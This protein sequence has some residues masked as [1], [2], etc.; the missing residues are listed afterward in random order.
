VADYRKPKILRGFRDYLPKAQAARQ[1]VVDTIRG[2][3]ESFGF[4]PLDTPMLE[5]EE[6]LTGDLGVDANKQIYRF[7]DLDRKNV[8]LP[9]DLTVSLARVVAMYPNGIVLP[10]KRYQFSKVFRFDKIKRGRFREFMQLDADIVGVT[11]MV[12]DAEIVAI[13]CAALRAIGLKDFVVRLNDRKVISEAIVKLGIDGDEKAIFRALDKLEKQNEGEVLAELTGAIQRQAFDSAFEKTYQLKI[14][15]DKAKALLAFIRI[16]EPAATMV[17]RLAKRLGVE[18]IEKSVGLSELDKLLKVIKA[19]GVDEANYRVDLSLARGLDYYTG[20]VFETV[21]TDMPEYGSISG[22]GRYDNLV[23]RFAPTGAPGVGATIGID[24]LFA[25]LEEKGALDIRPSK[26]LV[27]IPQLDE[28]F[29]P[30]YQSLAAR[31][32]ERGIGAEVYVEPGV[33]LGKQFQYADRLGIPLAAIAGEDEFLKGV[34]QI[35]RLYTGFGEE[36]KQFSVPASDVVDKLAEMA[37]EF[38]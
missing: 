32:R 18:D 6:T 22:G 1:W 26:T 14:P 28:Q 30:E 16:D 29:I 13:V 10:F 2:V 3:F 15:K 36:D 9:Y 35:K 38:K 21:M 37:G 33:K 27:F 17:T 24:R 7:V 12:S 23:A 11:D 20:T 8:A 19:Y 5:L 4:L 25:A 34:W 31:L